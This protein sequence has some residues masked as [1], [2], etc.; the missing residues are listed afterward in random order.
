MAVGIRLEL[1][2]VGVDT[3]AEAAGGGA[4][5]MRRDVHVEDGCVGK[6]VLDHPRDEVVEEAGGGSKVVALVMAEV[7]AGGRR[8]ALGDGD[9]GDAEQDAL[10][11]GGDGAR[12]GDVVAEVVAVVDAGD[13]QV[14][15]LA[16][17]AEIAEADT[18]D[19]G[20]VGGEAGRAVA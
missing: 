4:G 19:G 7:G 15:P 8:G 16:D 9:A 5:G 10:E 3:A 11:G 2:A 1:E 13:D 20:T 18:V 17:E 12:V 6:A 14:G